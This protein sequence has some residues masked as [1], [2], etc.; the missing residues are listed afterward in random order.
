MKRYYGP[1]AAKEERM[2]VNQTAGCLEPEKEEQYE[3]ERKNQE[4]EQK[5]K[6]Q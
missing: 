2:G 1:K 4:R 5:Q 6:I 3:K